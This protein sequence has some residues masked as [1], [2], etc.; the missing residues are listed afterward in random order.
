MSSTPI[1][2]TANH[3][4]GLI[5]LMQTLVLLAVLTA[6][7]VRKQLVLSASL[8]LRLHQEQLV[9]L[10]LKAQTVLCL[11]RTPAATSTV[12]VVRLVTIRVLLSVLAKLTILTMEDSATGRAVTHLHLLIINVLPRTLLIIALP[13]RSQALGLTK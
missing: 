7:S 5:T 6:L 2:L 13:A 4:L 8:K 9:Q 3:A 11:L 10:R 1:P 12:L